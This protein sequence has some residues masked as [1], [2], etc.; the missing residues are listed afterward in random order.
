MNGINSA[1]K[2]HFDL[3]R[4][5]SMNECQS[6]VDKLNGNI[7]FIGQVRG[8]EDKIFLKF[9]EQLSGINQNDN[10]AN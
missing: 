9:K 5:A 10:H 2:K 7:G 8:L 1:T 3:N 6:F 4:L